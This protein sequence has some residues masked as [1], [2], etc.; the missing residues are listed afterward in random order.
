MGGQRRKV[1]KSSGL[2]VRQMLGKVPALL[3]PSFD[4]LSDLTSLGLHYLICE[5]GIVEATSKKCII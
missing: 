5:I 4:D 3:L 2:G 1:L